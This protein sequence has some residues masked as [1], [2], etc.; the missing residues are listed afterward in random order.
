MGKNQKNC[1]LLKKLIK[2]KKDQSD[3]ESDTIDIDQC[4][5]EIELEE[6]INKIESSNSED[7]DLC[8][9][10]PNKKGA[11]VIPDSEIEN[12]LDAIDTPSDKEISVEKVL[13]GSKTNLCVKNVFHEFFDRKHLN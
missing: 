9:I 7:E 5:N 2:I 12:D 6:E 1:L 13:M 4:D 11:R 10:T 3:N 8:Y